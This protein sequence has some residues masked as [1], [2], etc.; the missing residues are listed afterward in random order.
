MM[1]QNR[2]QEIDAAISVLQNEK[3]TID[4]QQT[5]ERKKTAEA[6]AKKNRAEIDQLVEDYN[7]AELEQE[8]RLI[9]LFALVKERKG[10]KCVDFTGDKWSNCWGFSD[11]IDYELNV[12]RMVRMIK[13]VTLSE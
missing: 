1:K 6:K 3:N 9:K 4:K 13:N 8:K 2:I 12:G 11:K 10:F 7:A 5:A